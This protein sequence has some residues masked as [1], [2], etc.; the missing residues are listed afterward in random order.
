MTRLTV[1]A[2][3]LAAAVGSAQASVITVQAA[4]ASSPFL[5][6]AAEFRRFATGTDLFRKQALVGDWFLTIPVALTAASG[7][8]GRHAAAG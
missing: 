5:G 1:L 6:S 4:S 7:A 2:L 3:A 8:S